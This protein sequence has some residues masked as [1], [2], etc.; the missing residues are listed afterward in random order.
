VSVTARRQFR[1][2]Q[3][4]ARIP[5][6]KDDPNRR[7]KT[8]TEAEYLALVTAERNG[9]AITRWNGSPL[10]PATIPD[11]IG[12]KDRRYFDRTVPKGQKRDYSQRRAVTGSTRV[13][14]YAGMQVAT[15]AA[16][17][18]TITV[19]ANTAGSRAARVKHFETPG[20]GI[21]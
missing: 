9:G 7:L 20:M 10:Y 12:V 17:L 2:R 21:Y 3:L 15:S 19:D 13:A 14:R 4:T 18:S 6:L 1:F 8:I 11:L 16:M 5:W